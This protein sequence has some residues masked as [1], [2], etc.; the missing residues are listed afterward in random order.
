LDLKL[1]LPEIV[2]KMLYTLKYLLI[3]C[4]IYCA[5]GLYQSISKNIP[6]W[7]A[8]KHAEG[9][10][11]AHQEHAWQ[12]YQD[13]QYIDVTAQMPIVEFL[14]E[15]N[16]QVQFVDNI[17]PQNELKGQVSVIYASGDPRN[18]RIDKGWLNWLDSYIWLFGTLGGLLGALRLRSD[19]IKNM[20]SEYSE[21]LLQN[22]SQ[23]IKR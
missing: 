8:P 3:G 19:K 10:V 18:A 17:G 1:D 6:I 11:V 21:L 4:F 20:M 16:T 15:S 13:G 7:L 9:H 23:Y 5:I 14:D 22:D 2:E 12:R